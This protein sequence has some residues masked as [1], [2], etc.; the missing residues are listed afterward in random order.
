MKNNIFKQLFRSKIFIQSVLVGLVSGLFVVLFRISIDN[1]FSFIIKNIYRFWY[2]FPFVTAIGGLI[3]GYLVYKFA[4]ETKGS[5][6]PY[7]KASLMHLGNLTRVRSIFVKFLGG[8][9]SIGTGMPLGREG[10]SVQLG[11]GSGALIGKLFKL[12]GTNKDKLISAGAGSAIAATF[13][14][15]IAGT[16]F[17]LEELMQKFNSSILFP[18]LIATVT[19]SSFARYILGDKTSFQ[20]PQLPQNASTNILICIATGIIAGILGVLFSKLI[21]KNNTLFSKIQTK[22]YFKTAIAGFAAGVIGLIAPQ[23]LGSGTHSVDSLLQNTIP[24]YAILLIFALKFLI[25]P[26]C[27][28]SGV[29]GGIFLPM[30]MLGAY[31]GYILGV[32]TNILGF[33]VN[34]TITA[35]IGMAA[36]LSAVARTPITATVMV[37]EMTGGY[38]FILYI[39]LACAIADI[40]AEKFNHKP[41]YSELIVNQAK[42]S[43][44]AK[45]LETKTVKD[46]MVNSTELI[47][48]NSPIIEVLS[49]MQTNNC[50]F[51]PVINEKHKLSGA[52]IKEDI[53]DALISCGNKNL[54][55]QDI[56]D[57][58]IIT[59]EQDLNLYNLYFRLHSNNCNTAIVTDKTNNVIGIVSRYDIQKVL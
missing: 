57:S 5:G 52:I 26:F 47:S 37:F 43:K 59:A 1:I 25:T 28:G 34:L 17:V 18:V 27:F 21:H 31:L 36:F 3:S 24:F 44:E 54:K 2:V 33:D 11:A 23:V 41:I 13:N 46:I 20:I 19:A 14:A 22:P 39:M 42:N 40:T 29:V 50:D 56:M 12:S 15:P 49:K 35:L 38:N 9:A 48:Q 53:E 58:N 30:L 10:P 8:I 4:P 45:L 51:Y 55:V 32:I 6:I 16:I 7:V